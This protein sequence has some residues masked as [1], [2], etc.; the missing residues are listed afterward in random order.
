MVRLEAHRRLGA[1]HPKMALK[2]SHRATMVLNVPSEGVVL[3]LPHPS[4]VSLE[5]VRA[6]V[7]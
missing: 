1:G 6:A 5:V 4:A 7:S 2:V 3:D